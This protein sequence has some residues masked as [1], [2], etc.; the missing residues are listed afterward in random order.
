MIRAELFRAVEMAHA[1]AH[2]ATLSA[3]YDK[4]V[5]ER[6]EH[7]ARLAEDALYAA[8]DALAMSRLS[9]AAAA[10]WRAAETAN[11]QAERAAA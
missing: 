2:N 11:P 8:L 1:A 7:F 9:V 5:P 3:S 4:V 6:A 10:E